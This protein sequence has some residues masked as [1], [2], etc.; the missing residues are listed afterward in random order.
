MESSRWSNVEVPNA[1]LVFTTNRLGAIDHELATTS[2]TR[3]KGPVA[4]GTEQWVQPDFSESDTHLTVAAG[5]VTTGQ[6]SPDASADDK[7]MNE[8]GR[9]LKERQNRKGGESRR[10]A[11]VGPDGKT[12]VTESS[13]SA[14]SISDGSSGDDA[15]DASLNNPNVPEEIKE[16]LRKTKE[17]FRK[18]QEGVKP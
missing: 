11:V 5:I 16:H 13:S 17:E 7:I 2:R 12:T 6:W 8:A 14:S 3:L 4:E 18:L 15:F 10:T 9:L 1:A